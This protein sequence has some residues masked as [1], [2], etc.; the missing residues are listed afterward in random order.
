MLCNA[1]QCNGMQCNASADRLVLQQPTSLATTSDD[2][3]AV[4]MLR[5]PH[6]KRKHE[7]SADRSTNQQL[8]REAKKNR[9][10]S[11]FNTQTKTISLTVRLVI[12]HKKTSAAGPKK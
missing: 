1:M 3:R 7:A 5:Q 8:Y 4:V 6:G 10:A 11:G 2:D 12:G 9:G